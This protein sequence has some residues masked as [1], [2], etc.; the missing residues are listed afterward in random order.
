MLTIKNISASIDDTEVLSDINLEIKAGEIHA[1][2][3]PKE[4]GKSTLAHLIQGNPNIIRTNGS[5]N[6]GKRNIN[7]LSPDKRSKLGMFVSFQYP[8][9]IT[10][11]TNLSMLKAVFD[12]MHNTRLTNEVEISYRNLTSELELG[13]I[14]GDEQVNSADTPPSSWRKNEILQMIISNSDVVILDEVDLDL[15]NHAIELIAKAILVYI[16]DTKRAC[17]VITRNQYFLDLLKPDKVHILVNGK[18]KAQ[19]T[20]EL[21]KRIIEDGYTQFS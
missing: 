11:L 2:M 1:L 13:I 21:Y 16:K 12:N 6:L 19:G 8:P 14:H 9:E 20:T 18:I 15:D 5:I 4:S 3:G 17:M 10:G 7:K